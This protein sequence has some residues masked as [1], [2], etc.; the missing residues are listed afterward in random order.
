MKSTS[1]SFWI[2]FSVLLGVYS[3][4]FCVNKIDY[5]KLKRLS[6]ASLCDFAILGKRKALPSAKVLVGHRARNLARAG[7]LTKTAKASYLGKN[8]KRFAF[9][10]NKTETFRPRAF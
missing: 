9:R 8:D 6:N 7:R 5:S 1:V 3:T 4:V 2:I 10:Q